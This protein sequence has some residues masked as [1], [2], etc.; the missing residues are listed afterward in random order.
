MEGGK[1]NS[2][3]EYSEDPEGIKSTRDVGVGTVPAA[4]QPSGG[5][6]TLL[7]GSMGS[8]CHNRTGPGLREHQPLPQRP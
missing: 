2:H 1:G 7:A 5:L 8:G 6:Y 4:P 3:A